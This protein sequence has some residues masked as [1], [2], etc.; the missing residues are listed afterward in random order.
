MVGEVPLPPLFPHCYPGTPPHLHLPT[1]HPPCH[2]SIH[3]STHTFTFNPTQSIIC[4]SVCLPAHP[5][6]HHPHIYLPVHS[7]SD[8]PIH[9]PVH[10]PPHQS[11]H[12]SNHP[13]GYLSIHLLINFPTHQSA[14]CSVHPTSY[15][16]IHRRIHL[17]TYIP[18]AHSSAHISIHLLTIFLSVHP[19]VGH[20]TQPPV[21]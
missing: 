15:L 20:Y 6:N 2:L 13:T 17:S 18:I 4:P 19:C 8:S 5:L 10:S 21:H 16:F 9:P 7:G 14:H 11:I 12:S 1:P 3:P